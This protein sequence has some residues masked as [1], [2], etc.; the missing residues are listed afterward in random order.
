MKICCS[1][2][3]LIARIRNTDLTAKRFKQAE[4]SITIVPLALFADCINDSPSYWEVM[5]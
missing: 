4:P 3:F 2:I 1:I 5:Q